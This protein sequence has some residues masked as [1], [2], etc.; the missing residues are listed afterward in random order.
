MATVILTQHTLGTPFDGTQH[1]DNLQIIEDSLLD[2]GP[3]VISGL[4]PS[5]GAGLAV[6]VTAGVASIG[7][8]VTVG[9]GFNIGGLTDASV[10]HLYLTNLGAGTSNTTGTQPANTVKLGTATTAGGI[11]TS[12]DTTPASGRQ[13]KVDLTS[14]VTTTDANFFTAAQTL[15]LNDAVATVSRPLVLQHG[16]SGGVGPIGIGVGID[17]QIETATEGL[18]EPVGRINATASAVTAGAVTGA[19]ALAVPNAGS[20]V[21]ALSLTAGN[22]AFLGALGGNGTAFQLK[23]FALTFPSDADYVLAAGELDAVVIDVQAG[24]IT[25]TR[26]IEVPATLAGIYIVINRNAQ[27]VVL[28]TNAGTGI[29]VAAARAA[30][31]YL[32][33]GVNMFRLTPDV[34]FTV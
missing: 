29:T 13:E 23:R 10:N 15:R 7:G 11:V 26:N 20:F 2:L 18:Y 17:M 12:V 24:V 25:A 1:N 14:V 27:A 30:I 9:A 32:P 3:Y 19:L 33:T 34:D 4:V 28:K 16:N 21:T 22:A 31:L 5:A 6:S 8:R